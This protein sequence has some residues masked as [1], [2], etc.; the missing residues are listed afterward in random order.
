MRIAICLYGQPRNFRKGFTYLSNLINKNKDISFDFFFHCWKIDDGDMYET[1]PWRE[2]SNTEL[3]VHNSDLLIQELIKIYNPVLFEYQHY[4]EFKNAFSIAQIENTIAVKNTSGKCGEHSV[5]FNII[6]QMYSRNKVRNIL[7]T[8]INST[9]IHYDYVIMTRF[10]F[11]FFDLNFNLHL[12]N[13]NK[14]YTDHLHVPRYLLPDNFLIMSTD[15]FIK[16]FTIYDNLLI[17]LDNKDLDQLM[18]DYG[19]IL[20][21]NAEQLIMASYIYHFGE[22]NTAYFYELL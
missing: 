3:L 21:V 13:P 5:M 17:L 2:Y 10:D 18:N 19:E 20:I 12:L 7:N 22:L 16:W 6:S 15:R 11:H 4:D 14:V 1:N 9:N 8:Y